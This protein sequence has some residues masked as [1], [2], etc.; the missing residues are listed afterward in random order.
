MIM[1][2]SPS[3]G[4]QGHAS[5]G[6]N[7]PG[8]VKESHFLCRNFMAAS[9]AKRRTLCRN[10]EVINNYSFKVGLPIHVLNIYHLFY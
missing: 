7:K 8:K 6:I 5:N 9:A 4:D 3:F 1:E 2:P 10:N